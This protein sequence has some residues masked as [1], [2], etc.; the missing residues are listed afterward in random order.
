MEK[1]PSRVPWLVT[2]KPQTRL[3]TQ[4]LPSC[5]PWGPRRLWT[6]FRQWPLP[7]QCVSFLHTAISI[8]LRELQEN[9]FHY[10]I[11]MALKKSIELVKS[12]FI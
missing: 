1:G 3:L 12:V 7:R 5:T 10:F 2:D 4:A 11:V 9:Q 8:S 6:H